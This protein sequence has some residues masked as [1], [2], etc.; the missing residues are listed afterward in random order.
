MATW[1]PG[2][3][4]IRGECLLWYEGWLPNSSRFLTDIPGAWPRPTRED[5]TGARTI[6]S[7]F[8]TTGNESLL[9]RYFGLGS[10]Y[11]QS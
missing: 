2:S 4:A 5:E 1:R 11:L 6:R 3:A 9:E 10:Y 8:T 7:C